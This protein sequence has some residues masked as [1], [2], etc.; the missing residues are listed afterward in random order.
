[1]ATFKKMVEPVRKKLLLLALPAS[2]GTKW[3]DSRQ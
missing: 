2:D 1:M 3:E